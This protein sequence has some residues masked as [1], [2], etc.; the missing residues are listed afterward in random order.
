MRTMAAVFKEV[1]GP[2]NYVELEVDPPAAGEVQVRMAWAGQCYSDEHQRH[3][4]RGVPG[5]TMT[6]APTYG[7]TNFSNQLRALPV[8]CE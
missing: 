5:L 4:S 7:W 1:G 3:S 2:W 8:V 6:G